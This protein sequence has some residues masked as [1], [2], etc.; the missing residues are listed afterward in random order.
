MAKKILIPLSPD[1]EPHGM[2]QKLRRQYEERFFKLFFSLFDFEGDLTSEEKFIIIKQFWEYGS[3]AVSR[4]PAPVEA[5][6][7]EMPLVFVKYAIDDFD[8]YM[9]PLHFHNAPLKTSKAIS[10]K[11][12]EIGKSGVIVYLNEYARAFPASGAKQTAA[13]YISQIVNAK[14]TCATNILLHKVPVVIPCDEDK[15]DAYQEVMRKIFSDY[16]AIFAPASIQT[17]DLKPASFQVPYIIDKLESYCTRLENMFLDEVGVD[18]AKPVQSG[19]DR[20]LL[21]ETNAN[22]ATIN[23]FRDSMFDTINNGWEEVEKLFGKHYRVKPRA[24]KS[25][26]V[27]EEAKKPESE[28]NEL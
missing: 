24:A 11:R 10:K 15:V 9:R 4:S 14:M 26:S 5:Y 27:H 7:Q 22:N 17:K 13:R 25:L 18:N 12:L 6:E 20:L 28:E 8:Y 3:F 23:L 16:P 21:D 2:R 19:Q 1:Y